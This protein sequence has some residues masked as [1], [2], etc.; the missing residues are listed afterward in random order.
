MNLP[1]PASHASRRRPKK[2]IDTG[3][4]FRALQPLSL[5]SLTPCTTRP[6]RNWPLIRRYP[7]IVGDSV[8]GAL[9]KSVLPQTD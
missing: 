9:R 6:P 4:R 1:R 8:S 5:E 7:R 3:E 2:V